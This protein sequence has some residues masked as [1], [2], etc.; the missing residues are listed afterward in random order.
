M[1]NE[2][3]ATLENCPESYQTLLA[4]MYGFSPGTGQLILLRLV[5]L[6]STGVLVYVPVVQIL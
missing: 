2:V 5:I 6:K 1:E 3:K 4:P